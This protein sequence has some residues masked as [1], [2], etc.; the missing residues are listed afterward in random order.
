MKDSFFRAEFAKAQREEW[1][2]PEKRR[3][4]ARNLSPMIG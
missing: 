2:L 3:A 1:T 4:G